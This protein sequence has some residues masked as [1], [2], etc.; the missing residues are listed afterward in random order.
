M[1]MSK[2]DNF[3]LDKGTFLYASPEQL[4]N[5]KYSFKCDVWAAG[6]IAYQLHFGIHPFIDSKP[7]NTLMNIKKLTENK[8]IELDPSTDASIAKLIGLCLIY[9]DKERASWREIWLSRL[10]SPKITGIKQFVE[11]LKTMSSIASWITKEFWKIRKD[12]TISKNS[13]EIFI[14]F[15]IKFQYTNLKMALKIL[16]KSPN[17]RY[18]FDETAFRDY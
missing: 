6:C 13:D 15:L 7:H 12:F 4:R 16:K 14:Y 9:D 17:Y 5:E 3:S 8:F 10:F 1:D 18:L 11:Y 2:V